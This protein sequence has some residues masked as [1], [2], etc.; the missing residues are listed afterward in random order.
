[1]VRIDEVN[2]INSNQNV[3]LQM[4]QMES[5]KGVSKEQPPKQPVWLES[6]F[7][8]KKIEYSFLE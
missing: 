6:S 2:P 8:V 4:L 1:M 7:S 5:I 3:L